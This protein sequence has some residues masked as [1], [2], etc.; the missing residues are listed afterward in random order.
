M[1]VLSPPERRDVKGEGEEREVQKGGK[2]Q[3]RVKIEVCLSEEGKGERGGAMDRCLGGGY[4]S[5]NR[6]VWFSN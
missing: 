5:Q 2:D 6:S 4:K 3:E 1:S